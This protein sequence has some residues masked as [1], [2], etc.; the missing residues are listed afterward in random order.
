MPEQIDSAMWLGLSFTFYLTVYSIPV[1]YLPM[2]SFVEDIDRLFDSFNSVKHAA[3]G[4]TLFRPG[5]DN[6]PQIG[7][8]TKA[9]IGAFF[10][11]SLYKLL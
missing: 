11:Q 6:S 9:S 1:T 3:P 8:W 2:T 7:H 10:S 4:K 5:S